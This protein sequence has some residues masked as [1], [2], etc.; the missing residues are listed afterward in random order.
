[1][2]PE[3]QQAIAIAANEG[4]TYQ[5]LFQMVFLPLIFGNFAYTWLS[6]HGVR[7]EIRDLKDNHLLHIQEQI[8]ELKGKGQG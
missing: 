6:I 5:W 3:V 1:M 2:G 4:V 8:D 7:K